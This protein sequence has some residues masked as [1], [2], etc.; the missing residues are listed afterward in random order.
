MSVDKWCPWNLLVRLFW[1]NIIIINRKSLCD[2]KKTV[3]IGQLFRNHEAPSS[4]TRRRRTH[5]FHHQT[6]V[7]LCVQIA[8]C[9]QAQAP[10][11][12]E[13]GVSQGLHG[14]PLS[15]VLL[16]VLFI[17]CLC[18]L[19]VWCY[20]RREER[21]PQAQAGHTAN[22]STQPYWL[23]K[24]QPQRADTHSYTHKQ[25]VS[26]H[27]LQTVH[28]PSD[29]YSLFLTSQRAYRTF[30]RTVCYCVMCV[31][32]AGLA[33]LCSHWAA[34]IAGVCLACAPRVGFIPL[35]QAGG[36]YWN[37]FPPLLSHFSLLFSPQQ[38]LYTQS[39]GYAARF[40]LCLHFILARRD[41]SL[42]HS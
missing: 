10:D 41:F 33:L 22:P 8:R 26:T 2:T 40:H 38:S 28:L 16:I 19:M 14:L 7:F 29:A 37:S 35:H 12:G 34:I 23:T 9:A 20:V 39:V 3:S 42:N 32:V 17:V 6:Y 5:R 27:F 11:Q 24:V 30:I 4:V 25:T 1:K 21:L 31:C 13:S 15:S 36:V 18:W